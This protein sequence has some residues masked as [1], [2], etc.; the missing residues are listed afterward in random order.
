MKTNVTTPLAVVMKHLGVTQDE[1]A[2][3]C[4]VGQGAISKALRRCSPER[5]A[6]LLDALGPP[7]RALI[8]ERHLIYPERYADFRIPDLK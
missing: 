3:R 6:Q 7:A 1:L 8:D 4:Q 5:A 2:G